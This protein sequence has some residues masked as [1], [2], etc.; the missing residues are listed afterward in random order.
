MNVKKTDYAKEA[1]CLKK[2]L[3]TLFLIISNLRGAAD[4]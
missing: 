1:Y 2:T 4:K 3:Y